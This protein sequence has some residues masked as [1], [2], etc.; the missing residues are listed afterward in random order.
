MARPSRAKAA[1]KAATSASAAEL[2][3][4]LP[5][6]DLQPQ[7]AAYLST[8]LRARGYPPRE[9]EHSL[10][11]EV[12]PALAIHRVADL[13]LKAV[14][15]LEPGILFTERQFGVLELHSA[16]P[17]LLEAAGAAVLAGLGAA[18]EDQ[19]RPA[20]LFTD[21]IEELDDRHAIVLNRTRE[22][23]MILPGQSLLVYE[24]AP[25]L[26]AAVAANEA[27]KAA[28]AVTLVDVQMIGASGRVFL[29]GRSAELALAQAR[30][31]ET[32]DAVEG[33]S[34]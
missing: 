27:E 32:L 15:E 12:A 14:E 28:P 30:I 23:S 20:T 34:G 13:A 33:R 19:M 11:V 1:G 9:G 26:F 6:A 3:V 24:M 5:I 21:I 8:P 31:A 10:I 22:A 29:A 18:P 16:D 4:Y 17:A 7:F 25:A 2:R